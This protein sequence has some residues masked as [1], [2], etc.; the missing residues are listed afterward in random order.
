[1]K[2]KI[3]KK[4][5]AELCA[6]DNRRKYYKEI[7]DY[8]IQ[9]SNEYGETIRLE[10]NKAIDK[11]NVNSPI[12]VKKIDKDPFGWAFLYGF[13]T[14]KI[15]RELVKVIQTFKDDSETILWKSFKNQIHRRSRKIFVD[16]FNYLV[17]HIH[18]SSSGYEDFSNGN[19][20]DLMFMSYMEKVGN[21]MNQEVLL[22]DH[23]VL[24]PLFEKINKLIAEGPDI[25]SRIE[26]ERMFY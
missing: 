8:S 26:L 6:Y 18:D 23:E 4:T 10:L 5:Q 11:M 16:M 25:A 21:N 3:V 12:K 7:E 9:I 22:L 2:W 20:F 19:K 13:L 17:R 15:A 14:V 1:M 24:T